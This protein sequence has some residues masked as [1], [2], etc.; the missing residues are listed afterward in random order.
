VVHDGVFEAH[1]REAG[2]LPVAASSMEW[3]TGWR[4]HLEFA[5]IVSPAGRD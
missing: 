1:P 5:E 3:Y 2:P 4:D